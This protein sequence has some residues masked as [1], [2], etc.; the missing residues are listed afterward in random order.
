MN[1]NMN[2]VD[3]TMKLL[4]HVDGSEQHK[5]MNE[6][7]KKQNTYTQKQHR[8]GSASLEQ[9]KY[10]NFPIKEGSQQQDFLGSSNQFVKLNDYADLN[11]PTSQLEQSTG[12]SE[13]SE[14][15]AFS[16]NSSKK[17]RK[18]KKK[19]KHQGGDATFDAQELMTEDLAERS[20]VMDT[21]FAVT[22]CIAMIVLHCGFLFTVVIALVIYSGQ[23]TTLHHQVDNMHSIT[24]LSAEVGHV[25]QIALTFI[26]HESLGWRC[27]NEIDGIIPDIQTVRNDLLQ[28]ADSIENIISEVYN[29][30]EFLEPWEALDLSLYIF[31]MKDGVIPSTQSQQSNKNK[32]QNV[33]D[34]CIRIGVDIGSDI[35][36]GDIGP[37]SGVQVA[38]VI[39]QELYQTSL[40]K[41]LT[42]VDNKARNLGQH[43]LIPPQQ[44]RYSIDIMF[45]AFNPFVP[46]VNQLKRSILSV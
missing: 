12:Y 13:K 1:M 8:P 38:E 10:S 23:L 7:W 42:L 20:N 35:G 39:N 34:I 36:I 9:N 18:R 29:S 37:A 2:G 40:L 6:G 21:K 25:A 3:D 31:E 5:Q 27:A 45:L 32:Q 4:P 33:D 22:H 43:Q 41:S 28:V 46:I 30:E 11:N 44:P 15:H 16:K 14:S 17:K 19:K 26:V 24:L